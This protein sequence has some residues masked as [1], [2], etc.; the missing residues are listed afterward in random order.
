MHRGARLWL[1]LA[2]RFDGGFAFTLELPAL[3]AE[4][5]MNAPLQRCDAFANGRAGRHGVGAFTT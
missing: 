2:G 3:L 4:L 1:A 5:A